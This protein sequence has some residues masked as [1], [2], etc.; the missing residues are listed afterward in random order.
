[1][2]LVR[3]RASFGTAGSYGTISDL[4]SPPECQFVGL[5][6]PQIYWLLRRMHAA[7][8]CCALPH[9]DANA[10]QRSR[11]TETAENRHLVRRSEYRPPQS[12]T[13][14]LPQLEMMRHAELCRTVASDGRTY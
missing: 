11:Q 14:A 7:L 1:G 8:G 6:E 13:S 5:A 9:T 3:A 4:R 10:T 12:R 2:R